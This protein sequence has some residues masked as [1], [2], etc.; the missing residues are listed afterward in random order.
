MGLAATGG[1]RTED[2]NLA[3]TREREACRKNRDAEC[4]LPPTQKMVRRLRDGAVGTWLQCC[5]KAL[6]PKRRGVLTSTSE[7]QR[8]HPLCSMMTGA[9]VAQSARYK[10]RTTHRIIESWKRTWCADLLR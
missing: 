6:T 3:F 1:A 10:T 7:G 4:F 2:D 5:L 9:C 8:S